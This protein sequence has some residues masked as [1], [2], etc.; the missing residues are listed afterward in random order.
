MNEVMGLPGYKW[1][2]REC[3][4]DNFEFESKEKT[5][6]RSCGKEYKFTAVVEK[7]KYQEGYYLVRPK[8]KNSLLNGESTEIVYIYFDGYFKVL[9]VGESLKEPLENF[10]IIKKIE[11]A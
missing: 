1:N 4:K 10:E 9:R 3:S 2:C 11:V 5:F 7:R 8:D 6:C